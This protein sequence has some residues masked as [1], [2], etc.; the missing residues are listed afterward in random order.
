MPTASVLRLATPNSYGP[1]RRLNS[2]CGADRKK[3]RTARKAIDT[4]S[5]WLWCRLFSSRRIA[6][7]YGEMVRSARRSLLRCGAQSS[8]VLSMVGP[9]QWRPRWWSWP[10]NARLISTQAGEWRNGRRAGLRSRC[11]K[12]CEFESRLAH[13]QAV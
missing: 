13:Q 2:R 8:R 11:R 10:C 1:L 3:G 9:L 6:L 7:R 12:T 4:V 5:G